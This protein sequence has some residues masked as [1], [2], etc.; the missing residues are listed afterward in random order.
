MSAILG[1]DFG[2]V[3]TRL[4]LLDLVDGSY[5]L[6]AQAQE[7]TTLGFPYEDIGIGLNQAL[8][9]ISQV[10]GRRLIGDNARLIMPQQPDQVGVDD[11][12][13]TASAGRPLRTLLV[14]LMP[15]IS[16]ASGLRAAA[17]TYVQIVGTFSLNDSRSEE[18]RLNAIVSS[19]PDLVLIT[20]GT[21][22]GAREPVLDLIR[23]VHLALKL[24]E[25]P[26]RPVILYAGN[27]ALEAEI[28][29][30]FSGLTRLFIA[31]NVRPALETEYLDG[32]QLQLGLA[33]DAFKEQR[34]GGFAAV[35]SLSRLG[36]LPNAQ[37]YNLLVEYLGKAQEQGVLAVDVGSGVSVLSAYWNDEVHT[38]IR[39]DLGQGHSA[40]D[41]LETVGP[42]AVQ[43]WLPFYATDNELLS[44]ARNKTLRPAAIPETLR[45]LY[46]EYA[47]LRAGLR[48]LV[49]SARPTWL[50]KTD[51][52][53]GR[54]LPPFDPIIAAGATLTQTGSG[55]LS[56]LLLL[57][58]LQPEG[59]TTLLTDPYG[60]IPM[61][62][63]LA[64]SRPEVTVQA[65]EDGLVPLGV[66]FSLSGQPRAEHPALDVAIKT[67]DETAALRLDGGR[68]WV[69]P[70]PAGQ[71]AEVELRV[72]AR[73]ST[74]NG[75][76]RL[77]QTVEGG[78]AGLIFDTRGRPLRLA[79]TLPARAAQ[80]A[81]W[82]AD[83][84]GSAVQAIP[85]DW[86]SP[87]QAA[88]GPARPARRLRRV[89]QKEAQPELDM[90]DMEYEDDA[91][92]PRSKKETDDIRNALS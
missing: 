81:R 78:G 44:Y 34:G 18:E 13:A 26:R 51:L 25:R 10:T 84:T 14:G 68:L 19:S 3:Y 56:A 88:A 8:E 11:F 35:G 5:R 32:A 6:V 49:A 16:I 24:L 55:G 63:A 54:S 67:A 91:A 52:P 42:A 70:L 57:D 64:Y 17:G 7:R 50:T 79:P 66:S 60:L 61:L 12:V 45:E 86:L 80:M 37:S 38:S 21:E 2:S 83:A 40:Y 59:V 33:F 31:P 74:I 69:Y 15:D 4:V 36:V 1:A 87:P 29:D 76:R 75:K 41:L 22:Q 77:K 82:L 58:A 62:G 9:N 43:G 73:G 23:P 30:L 89:G 90:L 85:D 92:Q 53:P 27:S 28:R 65:L 47:L 72:L 39:T 20:G 71:K 48:E 46:L